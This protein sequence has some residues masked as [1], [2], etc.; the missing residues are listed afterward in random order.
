MKYIPILT[1]QNVNINVPLAP[2]GE[3]LVAFII[4]LGVKLLYVY[5]IELFGVSNQIENLYED[6]WSVR[7]SILIINIPVIFYT[8]FSESISGGYTF[9]KWIMKLRVMS[10]DSYK[11]NVYQYFIR[12]I[13][14]LID[15]FTIFGSI[16]FT[17]SVISNRN[18]RIGD[19]AAGTT[20]IKMTQGVSLN[21]SLFMDVQEEYTVLFPMV[22]LLSDRDMQIIKSSYTKAKT[23]MDYKTIK[24]IRQKINDVLQVTSSLNDRVFIE[25]VISDY[26][27]VTKDLT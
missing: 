21:D 27:F 3:R 18:Q 9:G 11:T 26:N 23:N 4:D 20:V 14:N 12:W 15:V 24:L 16:G 7:A 13:F 6:D 8:L 5:G 10:I 22:T 19:I 2:I 17:S 1:A 25:R